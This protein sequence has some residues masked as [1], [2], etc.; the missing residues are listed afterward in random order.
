MSEYK[1]VL[2][3]QIGWGTKLTPL[4]NAGAVSTLT[5]KPSHFSEVIY[6]RI[7]A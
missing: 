6:A 3:H 5:Q 7:E 1:A 2:T 4:S